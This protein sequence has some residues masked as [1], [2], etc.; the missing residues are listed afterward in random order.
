MASSYVCNLVINTYSDFTQN[1]YLD[2]DATNS[3][4][5]LTGYQVASQIRKHSGSSKYVGFASTV[6]DPVAGQIRVG[7]TSSQTGS[8]K[9][10]R[11][12]YDV[13]VTDP[14]GKSTRAIEGMVL[15]REGI[16][17]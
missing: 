15:V 3:S 10:G 8:L 13:V 4:L 5:N 17:R 16:T 1:F 14:L 6:V 7:L 2:S 11:Y 12:L 9:P